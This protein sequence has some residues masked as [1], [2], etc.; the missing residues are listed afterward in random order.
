M[1]WFGEILLKKQKQI[2]NTINEENKMPQIGCL[3]LKNG[4]PL[5]KGRKTMCFEED[6]GGKS[7]SQN[8]SE[9]EIKNIRA[10][11]TPTDIGM[12]CIN[13]YLVNSS[14]K[15]MINRAH[16]SATNNVDGAIT[17][18]LFMMILTCTTSL[19]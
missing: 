4:R 16:R 15:T 18:T 17:C 8:P 12:A 6:P 19:H 13:C 3:L 5:E 14:A 7:K 2:N 9:L 1:P 10:L 11:T